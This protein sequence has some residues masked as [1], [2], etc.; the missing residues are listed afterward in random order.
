M[1]RFGRHVP[2]KDMVERIGAELLERHHGSSR[3]EAVDQHG[4]M[5]VPRGKRSTEDGGKLAPAH[6]SSDAQRI[7]ECLCVQGNARVDGRLLSLETRIVDAGAKTG[8]ARSG[9]IV[10]ARVG[11]LAGDEDVARDVGIS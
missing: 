10:V 5:R 9:Q 3:R 4:N 11:G 7:A 8:E 2:G 1:P 6:G